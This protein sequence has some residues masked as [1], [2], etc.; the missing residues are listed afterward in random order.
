MTESVNKQIYTV[1]LELRDRPGELRRA[2]EPIATH[3]GNLRSV[4]HERGNRTPRGDIPVEV[5][6]AASSEQLDAIVSALRADDITVIKAGTQRYTEE[7]TAILFGQGL[8]TDLSETL[9]S[10]EASTAA[11]VRDVTLA[12]TEG[13]GGTASARIH[14]ATEPDTATE[15]LATLREIA[16]RRGLAVVEPLAAG[17]GS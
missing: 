16:S 8:D 11:T 12:A 14:L 7:L 15:T 1:R 3:G 13:A 10:I 5:D 4:F 17:E 6:V 2:L 9:S